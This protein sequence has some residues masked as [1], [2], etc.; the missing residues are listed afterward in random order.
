VRVRT[1]EGRVALPLVVQGRARRG[2]SAR[3]ARVLVVLPAIAWQGA[4][5]VDDDANGFADTLDGSSSVGVARPFAF[6][7]LPAAL[8]RETAPLMRLLQTQGVRYDLT[9]DLALARGHG[10][11]LAG[12]AGVLF[13]GSERWLTERL[14]AELRDYVE[15]GGHVVSFGTD[16][17]RRTV[18]LTATELADPSAAQRANVFGE[19]T[20]PSS[21]AAA[22]LVVD[23]DELGLFRASDGFIGL[24]TRFERQQALVSGARVL[25]AAGRD[26]KHPAFVAYR[27]GRGTVVRAGT[28]QWARATATD[29]EVA[30]VTRATWDLLSR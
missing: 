8:G 9:T 1:G 30:A 14:D 28:P 13:A 21:S 2:G 24:F 29:T 19:Q 25:S 7:R 18:R 26:P 11:S 5:P 22:P 15:A 10:A 20:A 12:H 17:F 3:R 27:L 16:A 6:G 23:S 4:N